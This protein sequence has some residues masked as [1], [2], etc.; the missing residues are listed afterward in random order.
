MGLSIGG[1]G[2]SYSMRLLAH[3]P[4]WPFKFVLSIQSPLP[5]LSPSAYLDKS[6]RVASGVLDRMRPISRRL[7]SSPRPDYP[8]HNQTILSTTRLFQFCA[9]TH[10]RYPVSVFIQEIY[11][12]LRAI[13]TLTVLFPGYILKHPE[14]CATAVVGLAILWNERTVRQEIKDDFGTKMDT[15]KAELK[16]ESQHT[17][18]IALGT[19]YASMQANSGEG[20]DNQ[21]DA[22]Y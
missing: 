22:A 16:V 13:R 7:V 15:L 20:Y 17:Q 2:P 1:L 21:V 10:H 19:A 12:N 14:A 8:L 6:Y 4:I 5:H 3:L 9:R 11:E 18:S